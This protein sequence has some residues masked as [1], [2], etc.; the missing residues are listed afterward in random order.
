MEQMERATKA[1]DESQALLRTIIQSEPECV[2][3]MAA[4]GRLLDMNPAGLAMIEAESFDEVR[5]K[6][7]AALLRPADRE[8]FTALTDA[9]FQGRAGVLEFEITGLKGTRRR[10]ET[11]AVPLRNPDGA[12]I[13]MLGLT[14]DITERTRAEEAL[15]ESRRVL[16]TLIGNLPGMVYR[17][18]NDPSWTMEFVSDGSYALTGY[19]P[20]EL[21]AG[22]IVA[23][24]DL[25]HPEDRE[26]LWTACQASLAAKT[27]CDNEY[28]LVAKTGETKWV[29]ERAEGV[30][31]P[32]G[33]LIGIEG[34]ITDITE[35]KRAE[36]EI[37]ALNEALEARV[38][39]RT[40]QL[41][42]S[43]QELES[44]SYSVSHD[45][46][47]PLRVIDGFS[48]ALL[49]DYRDRLD[50]TAMDHLRR[51]RAAAERMGRLIDDLLELARVSRTSMRH[52]PVDLSALAQ[53]VASALRATEPERAVEVVI[54]SGMTARGD[55][56]LLRIALENLLGN[57]W[58]FTGRTERPRIE[59]G[60]RRDD[61]EAVYWVRDNGAG[62]DMA[63]AD[64]LFGTFQ[65]LHTAAEFPGT[66]VGLAI[67]RRVVQRHGGRVW[68]EGAPGKGAA[69]YFTL[70]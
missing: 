64:R 44:F 56:R 55:H 49:D 17:C 45:L 70:A 67:V 43:N 15:T 8:A 5:G 62:F 50:E 65:R 59:F 29:W 41:A 37:K 33:V 53:A 3:L 31:A 9:V 26:G 57:A 10:L 47:A 23:Y 7:L 2:K 69:L 54:E 30:Y 60:V 36:Q 21:E 66:G 61:D 42:G 38:A 34:F 28:R 19:R 51:I 63:Y 18:R 1:L 11:H 14:R 27:R 40:A 35:R 32:D 68:A 20:A 6:S 25:I 46:R 24:G 39:R 22:G 16:A 4:D 58:K 48:K 13:A 12:I 52:E